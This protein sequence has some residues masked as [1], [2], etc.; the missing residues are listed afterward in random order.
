M[1][2]P[3]IGVAAMILAMAA[4]MTAAGAQSPMP[5]TSPSP[6]SQVPSPAPSS[7]VSPS[8]A[9]VV[10]DCSAV[11]ALLPASV[12]DL[13]LDATTTSGVAAIDPDELLDP[14]LAS[15]GRARSDVCVVAF[16]YGD[17]PDALAGQLLHIAGAAVPDLAARFADA[18]RLQLVAYGAVASPLAVESDGRPIWTLAISADGTHSKIVAAQLDDT[19]LLTTAQPAMDR[20]LA[21]LSPTLVKAST[22]DP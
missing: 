12:D 5:S 3:W 10:A 21:L 6:V 16:R 11:A 2:R 13:T 17:S 20:L 18:L 15:L 7:A 19:L 1:A 22:P 4:G 8:P 14:L 9:A